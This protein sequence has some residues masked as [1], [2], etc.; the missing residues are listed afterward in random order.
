[1]FNQALAPLPKILIV[2]DEDNLRRLLMVTLNDGR[3][4]LFQAENGVEALEM[5]LRLKPEI[6]VLDVMMPG[7]LSGFEVCRQIK[8]NPLLQNTY[9]ILLSALGR[10]ENRDA[11][12][13]AHA[14]AYVVKPFS[15][16]DLLDMIDTRPTKKRVSDVT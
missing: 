7:G 8:E 1:M 6:I 4:Q 12:F 5:A 10:K 15:P 11:G 14:D 3:Y 13:S 9:V 2:D 16:M